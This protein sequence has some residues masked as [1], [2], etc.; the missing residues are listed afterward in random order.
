MEDQ[1]H[2]NTTLDMQDNGDS[3]IQFPQDRLE[4]NDNYWNDLVNEAIGSDQHIMP[5][6]I[7]NDAPSEH[8]TVSHSLVYDI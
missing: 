6:N 2:C 5:S 4:N 7:E 1:H 8:Y 3:G